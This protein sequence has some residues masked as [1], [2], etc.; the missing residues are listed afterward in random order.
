VK[1]RRNL[2]LIDSGK[3]VGSNGRSGA[4]GATSRGKPGAGGGS[5]R[6]S[7]R[8]SPYNGGMLEIGA[9]ASLV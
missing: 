7:R 3:R 9:Y 6:G 4:V 8:G 2:F 5:R 1:P